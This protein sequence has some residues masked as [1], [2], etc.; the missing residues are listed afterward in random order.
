MLCDL[1][2]CLPRILCGVGVWGQGRIALKIHCS[3]A[4]GAIPADS[5]VE[6]GARRSPYTLTSRSRD[7][8]RLGVLSSNFWQFFQNPPA[9]FFQ[10]RRRRERSRTERGV[11]GRRLPV[12]HYLP[13]PPNADRNPQRPGGVGIDSCGRSN[14]PRLFL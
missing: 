12:L 10:T 14:T 5:L 3:L 6:R 2:L 4:F 11:V 8:W 9:F 13:M 7:S 1:T